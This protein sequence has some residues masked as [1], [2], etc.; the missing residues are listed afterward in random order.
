MNALVK[1]GN[2]LLDVSKRFAWLPPL[3]ARLTIACVF[4]E[5]GWGKIHHIDKVIGFFESL[6]LPAPAFQAHLVA[7][8]EFIAGLLILVGL[9]TRLASIPLIIVMFVA[10]RTAFADKLAGSPMEDFSALTGIAEYLYIV[11]L[12]WLLIAGPGRVA[13]DTLIAR[14]FRE[15]G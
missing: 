2:L 3:L 1:L 10:L 9:A 13:L 11:L 15:K 6:G 7:N 5:S 12:A 4:I 8:T 14:K